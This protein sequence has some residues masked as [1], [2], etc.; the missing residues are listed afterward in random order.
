MSDLQNNNVVFFSGETTPLE[1]HKAR[2][3][4]RI[5]LRDVEK[6]REIINAAGNNT[7]LL[8]NRD[9]FLDMLTD[10]GVNAM[11]EAQ[12][13]AMMLA[14]DSYA[15]S[16]TYYR[17]EK[18]VQDFFGFKYFL[19]AHQGRACE[20]ILAIAYVKPG[21]TVIT[22]YHFTTTKGHITRVGGQVLEAVGE[23]ALKTV[24][25]NPFKGNFD[26]AL[27]DQQVT[28][29]GV[30]NVSF[31][32]IEAGTNLI[33]GQPIS[34]ANMR[35]VSAYCRKKGLKLV[36]DASLLADNLYFIKTREKE[37][38]DKSLKELVLEIASLMDIIYFSGRKLGCARG[39]G[40]SM[41]HE[42]DYLR[43]RD[44]VPMFEGF[45]TYGGMSV[46]EM[47]A[48]AVGIRETLDFHVISQ[49]P[50]F[51]EAL[52]QELIKKNVPVVTPL[53]GLGCHV[54]AGRFAPHIPQD[55]YPSGALAAAIYITGGIRGMERGTL[56]EQ[57]A[58][59]GSERFSP[60]ELVRLAVPK[61]VFTL[62]QMK[63]VADRLGWLYENRDLVGGLVFV[64]EPKTLRF[65][66][67][68]L[69]PVGDWQERLVA[70]FKRDMP[71]GL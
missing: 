27:L 2:M 70:A 58:P 17:L 36:Y 5:Y 1:M 10:S 55:Q 35:E 15:G 22:N 42:E 50:I 23:E 61:R 34:L 59:D 4:Q 18:T 46:R 12:Y 45:L 7:F 3:V 60:M 69:K 31:V 53:G 30:D 71:S 28:E 21:Q 41:T 32:R 11:S 67:G 25:D 43:M 24:S 8:P 68:R 44:L 38:F 6:R 39:G 29:T 64:D 33:G 47:E 48:M 66:L 52:G 20:N 54:D 14:D 40:I 63:F 13:A 56:S 49:T 9:V 65:F 26:L 57:R 16:E 51:V 19:P 62:S 37:A